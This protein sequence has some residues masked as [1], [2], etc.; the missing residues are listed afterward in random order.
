MLFITTRKL[1][2]VSRSLS[3]KRQVWMLSVLLIIPLAFT[4]GV[5][6]TNENT[7]RSTKKSCTKVCNTNNIVGIIFLFGQVNISS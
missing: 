7:V 5:K 6:I 4:D 3:S 2:N 1:R